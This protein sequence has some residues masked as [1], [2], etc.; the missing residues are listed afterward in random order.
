MN[1]FVTLYM[2]IHNTTI[3][4]VQVATFGPWLRYFRIPLSLL[5]GV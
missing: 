1:L 2:Q 3:I 5:C 4:I